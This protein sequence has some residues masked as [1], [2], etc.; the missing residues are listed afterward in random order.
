LTLGKTVARNDFE[1][2][3][4]TNFLSDEHEI[5]LRQCVIITGRVH[6]GETSGSFIVEGMIRFLLSNDDIA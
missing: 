3:L 2:L 6:P 4:I 1:C 5:A